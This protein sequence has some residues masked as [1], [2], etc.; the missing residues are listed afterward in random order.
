LVARIGSALT[1]DSR[2]LT[3]GQPRTPSPPNIFS[4]PSCNYYWFSEDRRGTAS[5]EIEHLAPALTVAWALLNWAAIRSNVE[6]KIGG[7]MKTGSSMWI[8]AVGLTAITVIGCAG[9]PMTTREKGVGIGALG[10]AAAGGLI[11]TAF[12]RPGTG[13][14]IGAGVGLGAGALIGDYMQGQERDEYR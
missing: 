12:G 13:A 2:S 7:K 11:G 1:K 5:G 4:P 3:T 6:N 10:G 8:A 14:A 9:G